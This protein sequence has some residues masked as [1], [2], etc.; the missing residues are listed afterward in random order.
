MRLIGL[1]VVLAVGL[2]AAPLA[3]DGQR[4]AKVPRI[5]YLIVSPLADPPS[6]ERV[7]FLEG[8]RELG[9]VPG[10][11]VTIEYRAAN[12]N[13]ELLPNL[14]AELVE[15]KVDVIVTATGAIEA[16]QQA[17]TTI[18]IVVPSLGPSPV[19]SGLIASFARPGGN[20]TGLAW[21]PAEVAGKRLALLK[22]A[23]PKISRVAVLWESTDTGSA[24]EWR[25][26]Q[27]A[28]RVLEVT[29]QPLEIGGPK[30]FP[31][32]FA[33]MSRSRPHALITISS[34]LMS[35]YRPIIVEFA[36]KHRLPTMFGRKPDVEGGALMSYSVSSTDLFR[37]AASYV[38]KILKGAKPA[39]LPVEQPTKFELVI[40]RKTAK[41]LG[42]TIPP[43][44]LGQADQVIE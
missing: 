18:P 40:N 5:G 25:Q 2:F 10:R 6:I 44:V 35:A 28:A 8:L 26:I 3:A 22:E 17:T 27:A 43:S 23:F 20:V 7:A 11:N 14:A 37:R 13:R 12:W 39:D 41:T 24:P 30:E 31:L 9:Y 21:S 34:P 15:L 1:A 36:A 19:E 4:A 32:A 38:D 42:L 16:A 33:E 29:L